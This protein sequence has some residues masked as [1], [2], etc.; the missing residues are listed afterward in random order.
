MNQQFLLVMSLAA[1]V[2]VELIVG[3]VLM[4]IVIT[5]KSVFPLMVRVVVMD[6]VIVMVIVIKLN[7]TVMGV[8]VHHR[9]LLFKLVSLLR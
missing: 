8:L 4:G 5:Q 9:N 1:S 6:G 3:Q 2:V 7:M